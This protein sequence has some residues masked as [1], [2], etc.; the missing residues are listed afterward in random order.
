MSEKKST[1]IDAVR[2]TQRAL[3]FVIVP[4]A[5]VGGCVLLYRDFVRDPD[6]MMPVIRLAVA[7][8]LGGLLGV[9]RT[10]SGHWAG[11]RTHMMVSLGSAIFTIVGTKMGP[12]ADA[13]RVIQGIAAGIGFLGAGTI[14]K[15]SDRMEVVGL[16]T[17][18]SI[19]L[20]AAI[21]TAAG[22]G[23]FTIGV[24]G[25]VLSLVVLAAMLPVE[26]KFLARRLGK[27]RID[28]DE[29]TG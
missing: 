15:L 5:I 8:G 3:K 25:T 11:L 23:L 19:W 24:A 13:T 6:E 28:E 4:A 16:T 18:S 14:L 22:Y 2:I 26:R 1:T 27:E 9:E 7:A 17:A 21:G 29:P 12:E 10:M 20:A